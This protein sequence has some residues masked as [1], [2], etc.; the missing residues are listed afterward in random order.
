MEFF[1][2]IMSIPANAPI[3]SQY[4][5][6][7][8]QAKGYYHYYSAIQ[9]FTPYQALASQLQIVNV[10]IS[11]AI[12]IEKHFDSI[13]KCS[14]I[15]QPSNP[16]NSALVLRTTTPTRL[17]S[18]H[19]NYQLAP[20]LA[21]SNSRPF[22]WYSQDLPF[23]NKT[24]WAKIH[25]A[26]QQKPSKPLTPNRSVNDTLTPGPKIRVTNYA[27]AVRSAHKTTSSPPNI[28][29]P[30]SPL[31][32]ASP[33]KESLKPSNDPPGTD[34]SNSRALTLASTPD[35]FTALLAENTTDPHALVVQE[36]LNKFISRTVQCSHGDKLD[37][38][39][40]R[41][42]DLTISSA[43]RMQATEDLI[44][45]SNARIAS[46][47]SIQT[48]QAHSIGALERIL[49]QQSENLTNQLELMKSITSSRAAESSVSTLTTHST[50]SPM[51]PTG[52]SEDMEVVHTSPQAT[53]K[54]SR[55]LSAI[56]PLDM[57][58]VTFHPDLCNYTRKQRNVLFTF[59][60]T[61][62]EFE[63]RQS[64]TSGY[65]TTDKYRTH[66]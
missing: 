62:D 25:A 8:Q 15:Q 19:S 49:L 17:P 65:K 27:S 11:G 16:S 51:L 33:P 52:Q 29:P 47:M 58:D 32:N 23:M 38:V 34:P 43:S 53:L 9:P 63:L 61:K 1:E 42:D 60:D 4:H 41:V 31:W 3:T 55:R 18:L 5:L 26:S 48:T 54:R 40:A 10:D 12:I 14:A 24:S 45:E 28:V 44:Q 57:V 39:C 35:L 66:P 7:R 36:C 50:P 56:E 13:C 46:L 20:F 2:A 59:L 64:L 21:T 6:L 30:S 37:T 22:I